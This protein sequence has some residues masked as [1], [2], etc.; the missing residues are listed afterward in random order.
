VKLAKPPLYCDLQRADCLSCYHIGE[1]P[2]DN[3]ITSEKDPSKDI[4]K[5]TIVEVITPFD[6]LA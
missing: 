5:E 3:E 4:S 6:Y 2:K 1:E